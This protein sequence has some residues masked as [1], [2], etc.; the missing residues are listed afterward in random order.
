MEKIN[1]Y[2]Q[3]NNVSKSNNNVIA[4]DSIN[5]RIELNKR[6]GIIGE[7]GSGKS[8]LLKLIAGLYQPDDGEI[9]FNNQRILGPHEKLIPGDPKIA[10]LSQHFELRNNYKIWDILSFENLMSEEEANEFYHCCKINHLLN[11][12][13]DELSGGEK[14]RI[15]L[16][17][18]LIT[19]PELLLLDEPFSNLDNQNKQII[20]E[21]LNNL[22]S[23]YGISC[24]MVSHDTTDILSWSDTLIVMQ[25]GS[26]IQYDETKRVYNFPKNCYTAGLL[27]YF[28]LL[29]ENSSIYQQ[30]SPKT[31]LPNKFLFVRP[32]FFTACND[33][34]T[35][36]LIRGNIKSIHYK[37]FYYHI[38]V[39]IGDELLSIAT[40]NK[41]LKKDDTLY[42][43]YNQSE[44]WFV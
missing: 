22:V 18:L 33:N 20:H 24:I 42:L 9:Y 35:R 7:T 27:G 14:Q 30:I 13:T 34:L 31:S 12:W 38:E 10:Y 43:N 36:N 23:K 44:Y 8:T 40:L 5:C 3:I 4:I 1:S 41:D 39:T 21:V 19:Q 29:S 11:R 16:A 15:A 32:H 26:I 28:Q 17:K 37:G 6:I 2:L 25:N